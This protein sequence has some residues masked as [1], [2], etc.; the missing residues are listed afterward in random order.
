[1]NAHKIELY[2]IYSI[3]Y[4]YKNKFTVCSLDKVGEN[5]ICYKLLFRDYC[6]DML[7]VKLVS[8][9]C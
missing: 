3:V 6:M 8:F 2:C 1:M 4:L 5:I 9:L 7:S